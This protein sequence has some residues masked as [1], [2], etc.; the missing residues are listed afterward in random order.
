MNNKLFIWIFVFVVSINLVNA[1]GVSPGRTTI[2]FESGLQK[3]VE[4]TV[5]NNEKKDMNVVFY[6]EGEFTASDEICI[7]I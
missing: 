2:N 3:D 7:L 6:V 5:F 1:I 4:F